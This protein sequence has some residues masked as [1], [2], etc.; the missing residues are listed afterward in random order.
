VKSLESLVLKLDGDLISLYDRR[1]RGENVDLVIRNKEE[2]KQRYDHA[3]VD[4]QRSLDHARNLTLS[5]PRFLGLVRVIPALVSGVENPMHSDAE[6]EQIGMQLSMEF[7]Q[8]EGWSPEDVSSQNLGFDVRS[9]G[10]QDKKRYIEVKA[11]A[12]VGP[13][14]LT[15]NEW[16]KAQRF[17]DDYYLYIILNASKQPEL[18]RIQNPAAVLQPDQQ[19]EVRYLVSVAQILENRA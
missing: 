4:L 15:Q 9:T 16:F 12:M 19:M 8:N 5:T 3:L 1:E 11:R 17:Q 14:A 6:I 2:Q 10:P 7:E 18:Y 13:I